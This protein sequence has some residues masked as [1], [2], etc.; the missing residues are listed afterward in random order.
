MSKAN[1]ILIEIVR[2]AVKEDAPDGADLEQLED[3]V[4]EQMADSIQTATEQLEEH[5]AD[6]I[7][8]DLVAEAMAA[9]QDLAKEDDS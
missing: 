6:N 1:E 3:K 9:T 4:L 8:C 7:G 5:I 2:N